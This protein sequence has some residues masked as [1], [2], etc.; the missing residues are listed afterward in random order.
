LTPWSPEKLGSSPIKTAFLK[1]IDIGS[2][3]ARELEERG[4]GQEGKKR[5]DVRKGV[6]C[7]YFYVFISLF[8]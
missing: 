1:N 5:K 2:Q 7:A 4:R 3:P 6:K 8:T